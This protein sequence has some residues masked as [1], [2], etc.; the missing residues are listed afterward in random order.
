YT[1]SISDIA[2]KVDVSKGAVPIGPIK[3]TVYRV[4]DTKESEVYF[5]GT[6][7]DA[8]AYASLHEG[9]EVKSYPIETQNT[10]VAI[11]HHQLYEH[12]NPGK[13][14]NDAL[15]KAEKP[16]FKSTGGRG[17][18]LAAFRDVQRKMMG[19]A[20]KAGYDSVLFKAPPAPAKSELVLL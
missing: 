15:Y 14:F 13:K 18:S 6:H 17:N 9:H 2:D 4:G 20:R 12:L 10:L 16:Y 11:G 3:T 19:Q 1:G 8:R 5:A 7:E